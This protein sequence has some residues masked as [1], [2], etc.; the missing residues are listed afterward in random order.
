M[1]LHVG[2]IRNYDYGELKIEA[3][4]AINEAIH[5]LEKRLTKLKSE[6]FNPQT[7]GEWLWGYF[8]N[9]S[10]INGKY[11]NHAWEI[12]KNAKD[13]IYKDFVL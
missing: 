10:A 7:V 11:L 1:W 6:Y 4:A 12:L 5:I 8:A 2:D 13:V 9:Y 3:R